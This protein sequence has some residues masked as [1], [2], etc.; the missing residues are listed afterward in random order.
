M[1]KRGDEMER[2][3][4]LLTEK[5]L[6]L[7]IYVTG[8]GFEEYQDHVT[9][10]KGFPNYHL[11]FC[12]NGT[13]RLLIDEKEFIIEKGMAFFFIP[14]VPHEY[15]PLKEPWSIRWIIFTG[16]A[17]DSLLRA[18][19]FGRYEV[20]HINSTEEIN[21]CY[22]KLYK[23]LSVRKAGN[24]LEASGIFY[25]FL[26]G[27]NHLIGTQASGNRTQIEEKLDIITDYIKTN[28]HKE[29]SLEELAA[30][31]D[32][33][34]SYLCRIFKSVYEMSP[35]TYILRCRIN[36]AKE[37][38]INYPDMSVKSIALETGFRNNSYFGAVF[39]EFE[40]YTPIRFREL[41]SRT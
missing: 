38:L 13:G 31:V 3:F 15:Y 35:F 9:R 11:A 23:T 2:V 1:N 4:S 18:V 37:Q 10:R 6:T 24:M 32:I 41:Y 30:L 5:D 34:P 39:K 25:S 21:F 8:V 36:A 7:P 19:N 29:L 28:Y 20:F 17:S 22:H 16:I 40:G 33:T 12:E 27:I 14:E 26:S